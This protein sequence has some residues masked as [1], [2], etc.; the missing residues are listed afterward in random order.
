MSLVLRTTRTLP[1]PES[2][3][4]R[5]STL[6]EHIDSILQ[7]PF[8]PSKRQSVSAAG[9]VEQVRRPSHSRPIPVKA[10]M[11]CKRAEQEWEWDWRGGRSEV[12][13]VRDAHLIQKSYAVSA[14]DGTK[15]VTRFNSCAFFFPFSF[16]TCSCTVC[17]PPPDK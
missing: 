14:L 15:C 5:N 4:L 7:G 9:R 8:S 6:K 16:C 12:K 3:L 10:T 1:R 11:L 13:A 2:M 17:V